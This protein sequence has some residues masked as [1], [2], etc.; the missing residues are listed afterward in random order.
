LKPEGA[1]AEPSEDDEQAI[2][3]M[4]VPRAQARI[5]GQLLDSDAL[6]TKALGVL[7]VDAAAIALMVAVR[8]DLAR[9]WWIPVVALGLA[10]VLLLAAVWPRT[11]DLGPDTR[12]FYETMGASTR[13]A[14]SRQMLAELLAAIDANE[15]RSPEKKLLFKTGFRL[16]VVAI[17]SSLGVALAS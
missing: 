7:G 14:A 16:L 2:L 9:L 8:S 5:D 1:G 13:L 3:D 17:L 6:D 12:R 11:F 10:G 15:T 4:L